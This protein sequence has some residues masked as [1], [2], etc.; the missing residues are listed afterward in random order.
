MNP[1]K[2]AERAKF[3]TLPLDFQ[4]Q[5]ASKFE[6][7]W[8]YIKSTF[9]NYHFDK[10]KFDEEG[11][12]YDCLGHFE[13]APNMKE[14]LMKMEEESKKRNIP[15]ILLITFLVSLLLLNIGKYCIEYMNTKKFF[16]KGGVD[17]VEHLTIVADDL[18]YNIMES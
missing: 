2:Y 7:N 18:D 11:D 14:I 9:S 12:W 16:Q 4:Y 1:E 8:D 17:V 10:W 6:S 5:D 15:K 3:K 13:L